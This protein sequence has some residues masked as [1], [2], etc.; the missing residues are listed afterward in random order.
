M[1][2]RSL[3]LFYQVYMLSPSKYMQGIRLLS[4]VGP[5][6][7]MVPVRERKSKSLEGIWGSFAKRSTLL[8]QAQ[9]AFT[10]KQSET[11]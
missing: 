1:L 8:G 4:C 7:K 2:S 6:T 3:A 10:K 9:T 5:L 11:V